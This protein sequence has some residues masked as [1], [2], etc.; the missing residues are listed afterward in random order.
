MST[1]AVGK[2]FLTGCKAS[3]MRA[4]GFLALK[5]RLE[6]FRLWNSGGRLQKASTVIDERSEWSISSA[7]N[8]SL[9]GA[10]W[11]CTRNCYKYDKSA[12]R[13]PVMNTP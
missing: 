12:M 4:S 1:H 3:E 5:A 13:T 8:L 9:C 6:G 7:L 11:E 10:G 2:V